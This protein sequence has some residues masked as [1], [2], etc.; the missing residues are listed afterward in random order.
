MKW[1][2][3]FVRKN[4]FI[5]IIIIIIIII[6]YVDGHRDFTKEIFVIMKKAF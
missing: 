1:R 4:Q 5:I 6:Y 3:C 2:V